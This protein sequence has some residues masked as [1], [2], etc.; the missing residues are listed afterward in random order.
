MRYD[1]VKS[2]A[3]SPNNLMHLM[4]AKKAGACCALGG[5]NKD[6]KLETTVSFNLF[7]FAF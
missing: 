1:C 2:A 4:I 5:L 3:V 6:I 7:K